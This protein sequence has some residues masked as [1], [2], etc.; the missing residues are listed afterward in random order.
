MAT[1][2]SLSHSSTSRTT[3]HPPP[4][5]NT[6]TS[7]TRPA[8]VRDNIGIIV[9]FSNSAYSSGGARS[10]KFI[11]RQIGHQI[12]RQLSLQGFN[13]AAYPSVITNPQETPPTKYEDG[14][15]FN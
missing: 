12:I 13:N 4:R 3:T 7:G 14:S 8:N 1:N 11:A 5:N 15:V 9:S 6:Q 2:E 10:V